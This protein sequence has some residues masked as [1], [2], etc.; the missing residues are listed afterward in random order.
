MTTSTV[1][2]AYCG[3]LENITDDHVPPKN[4]FPKPRPNNLI[5]VRCCLQCN[6][7]ASKDDEYFRLKLC[8]SEQ[9]HD[10]PDAKANRETVFRSLARPES[11]GLKKAFLSDI[12]TVQLKTQAG[13]YLG[14]RLAF[15]VD[16][17]RIHHV[18]ERTVRGL[19]CHETGQSLHPDYEVIVHSD[20]TLKEKSV[21]VLE[22]LKRIILIPLAQ[23]RP[24]VI[25]D[26][27]FMY[28]YRV[29]QEDPFVSAW[30]L[31]FYGRVT[32]LALTSP[33]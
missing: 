26:E 18:V 14:K 25:G 7:S 5:T 12:R 29:T 3:S 16:L 20:D 6:S 9:V 19:F 24:V 15:D 23:I 21:K 2:C 17:Q 30:A 32:F 11:P 10:H 28:R 13:I 22:E 1:G 33:S 8:M 27:V 31:T 4:I